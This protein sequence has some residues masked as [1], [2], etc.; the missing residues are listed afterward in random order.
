M[1][2]SKDAALSHG[3]PPTWPIDGPDGVDDTT[4]A[5]TVRRLTRDGV[6]ER[7]AWEAERVDRCEWGLEP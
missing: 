2:P 4:A 1:P 5:L 6:G 7:S 3:D